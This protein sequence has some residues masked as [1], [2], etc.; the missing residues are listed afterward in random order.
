VRGID[1][2]D[3][4]ALLDIKPYLSNIPEEKFRR[5]WL[6]EVDERKQRS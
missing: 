4:T 3:S 6:A 1:M 2:V 5:G